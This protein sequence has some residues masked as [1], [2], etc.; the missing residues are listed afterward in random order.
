[1]VCKHETEACKNN[2]HCQTC[3]PHNEVNGTI[4]AHATRIEPKYSVECIVCFEPVQLTAYEEQLVRNGRH[5]PP[6]VCNKCREAIMHIRNK[7]EN[8]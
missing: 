5:I 8:E 2:A 3:H 7:L 4:T 1:M 6:K